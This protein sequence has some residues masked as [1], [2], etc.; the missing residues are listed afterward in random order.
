MM[1]EHTFPLCV[2]ESFQPPVSELLKRLHCLFREH[3][4]NANSFE[5]NWGPELGETYNDFLGYLDDAIDGLRVYELLTNS[6]PGYDL[7]D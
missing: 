7:Q 6:G 5:S 1:L 2:D 4:P 3:T